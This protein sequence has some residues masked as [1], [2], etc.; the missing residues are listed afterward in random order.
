M[1]PPAPESTPTMIRIEE[2]EYDLLRSFYETKRRAPMNQVVRQTEDGYLRK[3]V[4]LNSTRRT[5]T[6]RD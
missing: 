2:E 5:A 1:S 3:V 4:R 6:R